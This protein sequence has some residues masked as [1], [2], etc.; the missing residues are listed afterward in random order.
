MCSFNADIDFMGWFLGDAPRR[1]RGV[2]GDGGRR[3][4]SRQTVHGRKRLQEQYDVRRVK[5]FSLD[6]IDEF[7]Q[8]F[9]FYDTGNSKTMNLS[10]L[11]MALRALGYNPAD[12]EIEEVTSLMEVDGDVTIDFSEF[13]MIIEHMK[14]LKG[15]DGDLRDA[16]A[17]IDRDYDGKVTKDDLLR[18]M[19]NHGED[20]SLKEA[21]E[22]I[23]FADCDDTGVIDYR[24]FVTS[25]RDSIDKHKFDD[26]EDKS[27]QSATSSFGETNHKKERHVTCVEPTNER[28]QAIE[29]VQIETVN[30]IAKALGG[31]IL[32]AGAM[33]ITSSMMSSDRKK[34]NKKIVRSRW[35]DVARVVAL[36]NEIKEEQTNETMNL[37]DDVIKV[38]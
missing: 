35:P 26:V 27:N 36:K 31:P 16:F 32:A 13:C 17:I 12:D 7:R 9:E 22:M 14:E 3:Q 38:A 29:S 10:E 11:E 20:L 4:T 1:P 8:V 2:F 18:L 24:R 33:I 21:H 25:L 28:F 15:E 23:K 37:L 19:M 30:S 34:L 6:E 5:G